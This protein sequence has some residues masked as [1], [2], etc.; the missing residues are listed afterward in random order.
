MNKVTRIGA[1]A[2]IK[3]QN[4]ILLCQLTRSR[5]WTLPGGG[6]EF[7]ETPLQAM[8]REVREETGFDVEPTGLLG[9]NA[10]VAT[11][12]DEVHFIQII[13]AAR[14]IS[15]E[16]RSELEG[17]TDLCAWRDWLSLD[18]AALSP[19]VRYVRDIE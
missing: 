10:F 18:D 17:T 3:N 5:L 6:I 13:Y 15:G 1:Y 8:Q 7:G 12:Q 9:T 16:M 11:R 2:V 19:A 4:D 14:I